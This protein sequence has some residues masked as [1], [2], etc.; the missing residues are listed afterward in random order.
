MKKKILPLVLALLLCASTFMGCDKNVQDEED[1]GEALSAEALFDAGYTDRDLDG[2]WDDEGAT[3]IVLN[4]TTAEVTDSSGK[5]GSD[6]T[7][8]AI[9]GSRVTITDEGTYVISG[10]LTDGQIIINAETTDKVQIVLNGVTLACS[11]NAPIYIKQADKVFMTLAEGTENT[12]T[13]GISYAF[14]ADKTEPDGAIFSK[15]DLTINGSGTLTVTAKYMDG[16]VSKDSLVI[17]GGDITVVASDDGIRGKDSVAICGGTLNITAASDGIKATNTTEAENG[18]ISVDGGTIQITSEEDGI[19]A[20]TKL[21]V[22]AG[23]CN[24]VTGGGSKSTV[25]ED[26]SAKGLKAGEIVYISGGTLN[27]DSAD[28]TIHSNKDV[29]ITAGRLNLSSGDD[30]I[31]A[32]SALTIDDGRTIIQT[33]YEGLEGATVTINGGTVDLKASDDGINAAGG[34]DDADTAQG[35]RN[36]SFAS[37]DSYFIK[38]TGGNMSIDAGG[39]GVDSNGNVYVSGGTTTIN[40]PTGNG[41]GILDY[42]GTAE[43]TGGMVLGAGSSGML[44]SFSDTSTQKTLVAVYSQN[45]QAGTEITLKDS[46]GKE[47]ASIVP[48]KNFQAVII[49]S[50]ELTEGEEYTVSGGSEDIS[51]TVSGATTSNGNIGNGSFGGKGGMGDR[52]SGEMGTPPDGTSGGAM[53]E[54]PERDKNASGGAMG[55]PPTGEKPTDQAVN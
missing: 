42:N 45:Q 54:R 19:Q 8:V 51:L 10:S 40:G 52:P 31:H 20:E 33:S 48:T 47:I 18:W 30:G 41:N 4:K 32:D 17:T 36:D 39:D 15:E 46:N 44:Q 6:I 37:N 16:I 27:I 55:E 1:T 38:I 34:S 3:K 11:N 2:T 14:G 50:S 29:T 21:Q 13:D 25:S 28:D 22:T 49:S 9:D 7:T 23:T 53:G 24:F 26:Q 35:F 12:V 5:T 43:I